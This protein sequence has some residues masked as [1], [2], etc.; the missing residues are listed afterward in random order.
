MSCLVMVERRFNFLFAILNASFVIASSL[1]LIAIS[2]LK[3]V[4][5]NT[6][7]PAIK[8]TMQSIIARKI[9]SKEIEPTL[10]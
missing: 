4:M 6:N 8:A 2:S 10:Q 1:F 5:Q 9:G 7:E 3:W